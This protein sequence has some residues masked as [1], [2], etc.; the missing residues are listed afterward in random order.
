M[1]YASTNRKPCLLAKGFSSRLS[2]LVSRQL[3]CVQVASTA[4]VP[5]LRGCSADKCLV[6]LRLRGSAFVTDAL[7]RYTFKRYKL[8]PDDLEK[9]VLG[10]CLSTTSPEIYYHRKHPEQASISSTDV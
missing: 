3:L 4:L 5:L 7:K 1:T 9:A 8:I 2:S 6:K 10:T